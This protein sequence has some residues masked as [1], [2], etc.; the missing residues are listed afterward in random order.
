M[1]NIRISEDKYM[2]KQKLIRKYTLTFFS[3]CKMKSNFDCN[4][5]FPIYLT[6]NEIPFGAKSIGIR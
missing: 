3:F 2:N 5:T 4:Y 6:P 1:E